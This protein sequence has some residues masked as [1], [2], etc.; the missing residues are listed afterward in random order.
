MKDWIIY[1]DV[2]EINLNIDKRILYLVD[3]LLNDDINMIRNRND[4]NQTLNYF[5]LSNLSYYLKMNITHNIGNTY[6]KLTFNEKYLYI[7]YNL[8]LKYIYDK[9]YFQKYNINHKI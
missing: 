3:K 1:D 5:S 2:T 8:I 7:K 9:I 6:Y 4:F